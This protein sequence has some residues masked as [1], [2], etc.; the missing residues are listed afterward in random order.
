MIP[1]MA[2]KRQLPQ[3]P[4]NSDTT[5][6]EIVL[7]LLEAFVLEL[8]DEYSPSVEGFVFRDLLEAAY[9]AA[10]KEYQDIHWR[11]H[12]G[13]AIEQIHTELTKQAKRE[14]ILRAARRRAAQEAGEEFEDGDLDE[15]PV[16]K[17]ANSTGRGWHKRVMARTR[18]DLLRIAWHN[19]AS[20]RSRF[21]MAAFNRLLAERMPEV[22]E[23]EEDTETVADYWSEQEVADLWGRSF[24]NDVLPEDDEA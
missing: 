7:P 18:T 20:A 2:K 16:F 3:P 12:F 21:L 8:G 14:A 17:F 13:N 5:S 24:G 1:L 10:W 11:A 19:E 6:A 22:D 23:D 9:P 15:H 4:E